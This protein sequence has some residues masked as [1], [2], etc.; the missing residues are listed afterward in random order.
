MVSII[1]QSTE[2]GLLLFLQYINDLSMIRENTL[3]GYADHSTFL[4]EVQKPDNRVQ[5]V[6]SHNRELGRIGDWYKRWGMLVNPVKI[7]V[8]VI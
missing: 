3:V 8:L 5:A 4:P 6:L 1:P 7:K 2:L